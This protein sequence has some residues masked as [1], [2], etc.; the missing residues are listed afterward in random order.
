MGIPRKHPGNTRGTPGKH[1]G[2]TRKTPGKYPG[3]VQEDSI[4]DILKC[5]GEAIYYFS[6]FFFVVF[7]RKQTLEK[8]FALL[9]DVVVL[10]FKQFQ[11]LYVQLQTT[12]YTFSYN[13]LL[14]VM[15]SFVG[16]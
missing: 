12:Y 9:Y 11:F 7:K 15:E 4:W 2:N 6:S 3:K 8:N 5:W 1:P 16:F 10:G 14:L 13:L